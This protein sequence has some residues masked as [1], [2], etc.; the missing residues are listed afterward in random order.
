MQPLEATLAPSSDCTHS[1]VEQAARWPA[2]ISPLVRPAQPI[3]PFLVMGHVSREA[4]HWFLCHKDRLAALWEERHGRPSFDLLSLSPI[5][6][7]HTHDGNDHAEA[8]QRARGGEASPGQVKRSMPRGGWLA[9]E[10]PQRAEAVK[11][12]RR[13][14]L[15]PKNVC[16]SVVARQSLPHRTRWRCCR[17]DGLP[18][19]HV[20]VAAWGTG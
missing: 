5:E 9:H 2:R 17:H 12:R 20:R 16:V 13:S 19:F 1:T 3:L 11:Q 4:E 14:C 18:R 7:G 8:K 15:K 6:L 10:P